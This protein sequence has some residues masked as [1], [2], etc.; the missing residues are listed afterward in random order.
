MARGAQLRPV[1]TGLAVLTARV[2]E[3]VGVKRMAAA[4]TLIASSIVIATV[5]ACALH[6]AIRQ[7]LL[8]I[9]A[10]PLLLILLLDKVVLVQFP[11]DILANLRLL[12][13]GG[14][15]KLVK[16]NIEPGIDVRMDGVVFVT[17]LSRRQPLCYCLCL[18]GCA[19]LIGAA[20]I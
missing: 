10:V 12:R 11:K 8:T 1:V 20:N 2:N 7:E 15:A 19:V 13:G 14:A 6:K 16:G 5:G 4:V 9:D 18:C 17:D 3:L